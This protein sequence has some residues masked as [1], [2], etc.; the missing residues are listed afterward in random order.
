MA[1]ADIEAQPT[2][3]SIFQSKKEESKVEQKGLS[4][5][6]AAPFNNFLKVPHNISTHISLVRI[7]LMTTNKSGRQNSTINQAYYHS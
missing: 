4:L 3:I 1:Y 2:F 6:K 7:T 5:A